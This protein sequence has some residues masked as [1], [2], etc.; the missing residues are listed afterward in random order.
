MKS[1]FKVHF[2][3]TKNQ[4]QKKKK[5]KKKKKKK[6]IETEILFGLTHHSRKQYPQMLQ[7]SFF[8]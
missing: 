1:G 6:K 7:K 8:S 3:Y 2:Q 4:R 5:E